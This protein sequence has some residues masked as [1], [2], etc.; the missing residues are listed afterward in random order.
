MVEGS[1]E[2]AGELWCKSVTM[3]AV[4]QHIENLYR[5]KQDNYASLGTHPL[6]LS[7]IMMQQGRIQRSSR[8]S[9]WQEGTLFGGC[10]PVSM[11]GK[12]L[13]CFPFHSTNGENSG[14]GHLGEPHFDCFLLATT[15]VVL[16]A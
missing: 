9:Q 6:P 15:D 13:L 11:S 10:L 8:F 12:T 16:P 4:S 5:M 3:A 14:E 2:L 7:L 1:L